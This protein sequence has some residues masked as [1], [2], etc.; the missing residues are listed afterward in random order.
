MLRY[1]LSA[2]L[3]LLFLIGCSK[4]AETNNPVTKSSNDVK[5]EL[6]VSKYLSDKKSLKKQLL[7]MIEILKPLHQKKLP[8]QSSGDWLAN[9]DESGQ[10]FLEY[11]DDNPVIPTEERRILFIQ[12]LGNFTKTQRKIVNLVTEYMSLY[13]N[14]EAKIKADLPLSMVPKS[15]RR[16]NNGKEQL[17]AP[18]ILHYILLSRLP[19]N[20]AAY[21][22]FTASDL[23]PDPEWNYVFGQAN[24]RTR[25]GVWSLHRFGNPDSGKD[26][27]KLCLRRTISLGTHETGHMFTLFHCIKYECNMCGTNSL[28]ETDRHP[29]WLCPECPSKILYDTK[30]DK[31]V[32]YKKLAN[33]CKTNE[34]TK[35]QKFFEKSVSILSQHKISD[36]K[37]E[38]SE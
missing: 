16:I 19:E 22:C 14:L 3:L 29:I 30:A 10:T 28:R 21:I 38:I 35:E 2:S 8:I 31:I 5:D 32:R 6:I 33:F 23:Y 7:E 37:K 4:S 1:L 27:F 17:Y 12:P 26:A 9:H 24:I 11:L 25:C 34:L 18:H 36:E 13:F 20:A 15:S